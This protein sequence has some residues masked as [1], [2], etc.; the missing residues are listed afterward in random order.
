MQKN[1]TGK[2]ISVD[3]AI[4]IIET[5]NRQNP[6]VDT[7]FLVNSLPYLRVN[8]N[9]TIKLLGRNADGKI[10]SKGSTFARITS[11]WELS[12][13]KHAITEHYKENTRNHIEIN[14][15]A[16]GVRSVTTAMDE[17][18]NPTGRAMIN[19]KPMTKFGDPTTG[20]TKEVES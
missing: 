16:I 4:E 17:D 19:P 13:L 18:N 15:D 12:K 8:G 14:P 2:I 3:E 1:V 10:V 7:V 20:G 6:V 9:Y 5:D 11:D